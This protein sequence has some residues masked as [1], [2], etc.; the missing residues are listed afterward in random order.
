MD[1]IGSIKIWTTDKMDLV[2]QVQSGNDDLLSQLP[3]ELLLDLTLRFLKPPD[4]LRLCQVSQVFN[5]RLCQNDYVWKQLYQRDIST[6]QRP[7]SGMY[8]SAYQTI[9]HYIQQHTINDNRVYAATH[10]YEKLFDTLIRLDPLHKDYFVP[11]TKAAK[12]GH[13][14]IVRRIIALT[15]QDIFWT[16]LTLAAVHGHRPIVDYMLHYAN[17]IPIDLDE[18]LNE[19]LISATSGGHRD[20]VN[21]LIRRGANDYNGALLKAAEKGYTDI[22]NDMVS[23]GANDYNE[24]LL[25]AVFGGHRDIVN[26]II[27]RGANA[28]NEAMELAAINGHQ[29]IIDD[30]L[31]HGATSYNETM[32]EAARNGFPGIVNQMIDLGANDYN[33]AMANAAYYGHS[34]IVN[35]MLELGADNYNW[36]LASAAIGGYPAIVDQMIK[37]GANDYNTALALNGAAGGGHLDTVQHLIDLG[38]NNYD[39]AIDIAAI[40]YHPEVVELLERNR[41][42]HLS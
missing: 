16:A 9:Q 39:E 1:P 28:F 32:V 27:S 13:L 10:G 29:D 42:L 12:N 37:R 23:H 8:R 3:T 35:R 18:A 38:A 33:R 4:I 2:D 17:E 11:L 21:E 19:A 30:M 15:G 31:Q 36:A 26:Y 25:R 6:Q 20:L 22:V 7:Q 24:A 14:D 41:N 34:E 40:S 5:E